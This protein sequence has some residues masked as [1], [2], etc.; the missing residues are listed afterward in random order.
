MWSIR[1]KLEL[2]QCLV[3]TY[4]CK[5]CVPPRMTQGIL[6]K[7][8][9][10]SQNFNPALNFHCHNP[11]PNYLYF[12]H[13]QCQNDARAM[14]EGI[15]VVRIPSMVRWTHV[16]IVKLS[17][18][19]PRIHID[20]CITT[21]KWFALHLCTRFLQS[22]ICFHGLAFCCWI[23]KDVALVRHIWHSH[24]VHVA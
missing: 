24:H 1:R 13:L 12:Y 6:T 8:M 19:S 3:C 17:M 14:P 22:N 4:Q 23:L 16:R 11:L 18:T 20:R 15:A 7:K 10:I 21:N 5:S 9:Y 2:S